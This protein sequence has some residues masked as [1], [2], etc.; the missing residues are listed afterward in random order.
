MSNVARIFSAAALALALTSGAAYADPGKTREQVRAEL[1]A[2][3]KSGD[4]VVY[5]GKTA[6]ELSRGTYPADERQRRVALPG[7]A[8]ATSNTK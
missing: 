1:V 4:V 2:A 8:S 6:R 5:L 3:I 7:T